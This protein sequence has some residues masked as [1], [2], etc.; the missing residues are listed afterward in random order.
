MCFP[1]AG[2]AAV[3]GQ[4]ADKVQGTLAVDVDVEE[5]CDGLPCGSTD[6]SMTADQLVVVHAP[7]GK[8][9]STQGGYSNPGAQGEARPENYS[10]KE[11]ALKPQTVGDRSI[12]K[13]AGQRRNK[14]N[15]AH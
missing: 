10:V 8:A 15:G 14:I 3:G 5:A 4:G 11:V 12:V 1:P 6:R 7:L 2:A 9:D 13:G